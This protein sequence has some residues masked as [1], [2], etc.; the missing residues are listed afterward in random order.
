MSN[1]N[2]TNAMVS[3]EDKKKR[4][5]LVLDN[6]PVNA[7]RLKDLLLEKHFTTVAAETSDEAVKILKKKPDVTVMFLTAKQSG[8]DYEK[9]IKSLKQATSS[10]RIPIIVIVEEFF[11]DLVAS[12]LKAGADDFISGPV[13]PDDLARR[14]GVQ[15]RIR[16]NG[17][18]VSKSK[19]SHDEPLKTT[20]T[21][22]KGTFSG[23][24]PRL[25]SSFY[26]LFRDTGLL[27]Y[28]YEKI[29]RLG[30]GSFGEAWKVRDV[31]GDLSDVYVAK[32][33]LSKKLNAKFEKESR[34]LR[35]LA[36][37]DGI[38]KVREIIEVQ[39]K[40]VLIQEFVA[41]K[42]LLDVIER[43]LEEKEAESIILQLIGIVAHAHKLDV[44]HRDI[45]P[46]NVMVRPDGKIA[47]L[48]FGAAKE[49]DEKEVSSTVT[50]S[51]P[52]MSPEQIMGKSQKRSDVWALGVVMYVLYTGMFPFYHDVEKVLM[53]M[54]LELP[55]IPPSRYNEDIRP[56]VEHIILKCLEKNPENR[57]KNADDLRH[58]ILETFPDYGKKVLPLY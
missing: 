50:G 8:L 28:R 4:T 31:L 23:L 15:L 2:R 44:I 10:K 11:E 1:K 36:D 18:T 14:V 32:I 13:D 33:P 3:I 46:G 55:P 12:A 17:E 24:L 42:T 34:I 43:E 58:A 9:I 45:K 22:E 30:M 38:P 41:G 39:N 35:K 20:E 7:G 40:C 29:A 48:D 47:L 52:Y 16:E 19:Q 53:D 37:H 6:D 25:S 49:L 27:G 51:R 5:A 54:I 56:A 26:S 21:I 57:Y